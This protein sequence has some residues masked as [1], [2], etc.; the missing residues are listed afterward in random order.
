MKMENLGRCY[1]LSFLYQRKHPEYTL[2][3]GTITCFVP[4]YMTINHAWLM[5]D[6]IVYDAVLEEEFDQLAYESMFQAKIKMQYTVNESSMLALRTGHY[7][8]WHKIDI[9]DE[10]KYYNKKG[11]LKKEL[12]LN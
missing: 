12:R 6:N 4:P 1:E 8:A 11:R 10:K 7:G 5:K 9:E 3:H 2:I